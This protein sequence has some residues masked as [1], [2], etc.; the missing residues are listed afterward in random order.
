LITD[1]ENLRRL[2]NGLIREPGSSGKLVFEAAESAARFPREQVA[3]VLAANPQVAFIDLGDSLTGL[4][5]LEVLSREAPELQLVAAGPS[6]PADSLLKVMRSGAGEYLPRPLTSEEVEGAFDRVRRRVNGARPDDG[7]ADGKVITLFSPKGGVGVTTLAVNLAVDLHELTEESTVLV[8][9]APSLGTAA[10]TLGLQPR[11]SYLDVVQ[12]FHRLDIEL[13]RSF[14]QVHESGIQ[15]LASPSRAEDPA[16]PTMDEVMGLLR[17]CRKHFTFIVVDAGHALTNAAHVALMEA[18]HRLWVSTPE[19]PTLRNLKRTLELVGEQHSTNGKKPDR[20]ILNQYAEGLGMSVEEVRR[21][22][23][24]D[25]D[26]VIKRESDLIAESIN[27][28]TP[29][30]Q[31]RRSSFSRTM[32]DLTSRVAGDAIKSDR[33]GGFMHALLRPFRSSGSGASKEK[34]T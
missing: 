17:L 22:L 12:N 16:G 7:G 10:L 34:D 29:A 2:V 3:D 15:V 19:L 24:L 11:F 26:L 18:D 25:V 21:G 33:R 20:I 32:E 9:L 27:L 6:L 1:D 23:G 5:V 14:L 30:V 28:G 13:F 31:M 8:D 4:R